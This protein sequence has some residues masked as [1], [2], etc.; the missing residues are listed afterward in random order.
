M[1]ERDAS[2]EIDQEDSVI[3][4]ELENVCMDGIDGVGEGDGD[5]DGVYNGDGM[6]K[7]GCG[8]MGD[9]ASGY[10]NSQ[11]SINGFEEFDLK[12]ELLR[13]IKECGFEQ[14]SDVQ[15]EC[16]AQAMQGEDVLCQA[17]S[18]MGKTAVFVLSTL[19][20]LQVVQNEVS[21]LVICHTG[22]LA[23]QVSKEFERF[24]KYLQDVEVSVFFGARD[25][26]KDIACLKE[27]HPNVIVGTP[28]RILALVKLKCLSFSKLKHL[29]IDE[30]DKVVERLD[31]RA[32]VQAILKSTPHKKQVM[33]FTATLSK[34]TRSSCRKFMKQPTEVCVDEDSG[35]DFSNLQHFHLQVS[36]N[37]K[38]RKLFN[39]LK[40]LKFNQTIIFVKKI[41]R[42][43]ALCD[44]LMQQEFPAI[45]LHKGMSQ[46]ERVQ[47]YQ[48][49]KDGE[50]RVLVA[51][52][53]CDRG[54]HI[55]N[56]NVVFN[57]DVPEDVVA[58]L[59]RTARAGRFGRKGVAI[60]MIADDKDTTMLNAVQKAYNVNINELPDHLDLLH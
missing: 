45:A 59:H 6:D 16:L 52:G 21:V 56:V 11:V 58:Y 33:M 28:G 29:I 2:I 44:L 9:E 46:Q 36:H 32:D 39:L 34:E 18:G 57:Y 43:E 25:I 54:L 49:F 23:F 17:K 48:E 8:E 19:Q 41:D 24:S 53:L 30:C 60:T 3:S 26:T 4:A 47:R 20:Q 12:S 5:G 50:K 37:Q 40:T 55:D 7:E 51:T 27:K 1:T 13:A 42:C 10:K 14:P 35:L 38:N 31:S 22:M 15:R